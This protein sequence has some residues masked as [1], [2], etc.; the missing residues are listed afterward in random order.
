MYAR[1]VRGIAP[2]APHYFTDRVRHEIGQGFGGMLYTNAV[3][4][5]A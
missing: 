3:F 2:R 5:F 4:C 1:K